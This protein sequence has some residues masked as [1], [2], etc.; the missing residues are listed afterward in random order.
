[1]YLNCTTSLNQKLEGCVWSGF[2]C[3][4]TIQHFF[5]VYWWLD[6]WIA[7]TSFSIAMSLRLSWRVPSCSQSRWDCLCRL[8]WFCSGVFSQWEVQRKALKWRTPK[9][10]IQPCLTKIQKDLGR[11]GIRCCLMIWQ[12]LCLKYTFISLYLSTSRWVKRQYIK[13]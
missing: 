3:Y 6:E 1:M 10:W 7:Q 2:R 5:G 11:G 9:T 4:S 13:Y 12:G 8:F